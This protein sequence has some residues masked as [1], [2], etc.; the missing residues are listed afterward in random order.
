MVRG[1]AGDLCE[2][3]IALIKG[4]QLTLFN[5]LV[6]G[7]YRWMRNV[8]HMF[9]YSISHCFDGNK[10]QENF[11]LPDYIRSQEASVA[12]QRLFYIKLT[13]REGEEEWKEKNGKQNGAW[14][15]NRIMLSPQESISI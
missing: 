5:I 14:G 9:I 3:L 1:R 13:S 4:R 8:P 11:L 12:N 10:R 7:R 6:R 2:A 15:Q